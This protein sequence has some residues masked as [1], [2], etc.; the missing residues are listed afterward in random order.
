[1][2]FRSASTTGISIPTLTSTQTTIPT[3]IPQISPSQ[4]LAL[5]NAGMNMDVL[6]SQGIG[7]SSQMR[8]PT[9]NVVQTNLTGTSN[10]YSP[11]LYYNKGNFDKAKDCYKKSLKLDENKLRIKHDFKISLYFGS[12]NDERFAR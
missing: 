3:T 11:Y 10:I 8:G 5:L 2:L 9:T 7:L 4:T 6:T 12:N 1:M